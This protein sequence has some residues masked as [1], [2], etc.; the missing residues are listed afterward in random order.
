MREDVVTVQEN[1]EQQAESRTEDGDTGLLL[2]AKSGSVT[3]VSILAP[4]E[5]GHRDAAGLT[6]LAVGI[7]EGKLSICKLLAP[8]EAHVPL[9]INGKEK[10]PLVL[11]L[12]AGCLDIVAI[13][14]EYIDLNNESSTHGQYIIAA[15]SSGKLDVVKY[16]L[17]HCAVDLKSIEQALPIATGEIEAYLKKIH[18]I[19]CI[20]TCPMCGH[21]NVANFSILPL[22]LMAAQSMTEGGSST[23]TATELIEKDKVILSQKLEIERLRKK[24][25][26]LCVSFD[27]ADIGL[28]E[29]NERNDLSYFSESSQ[30]RDLSTI[31]HLDSQ[32]REIRLD[33]LEK[34]NMGREIQ[35]GIIDVSPDERAEPFIPTYQRSSSMPNIFPERLWAMHTD[36]SE[37]HLRDFVSQQLHRYR[38]IRIEQVGNTEIDMHLVKEMQE[39]PFDAQTNPN[40]Y[41][42]HYTESSLTSSAIDLPS[43]ATSSTTSLANYGIAEPAPAPDLVEKYVYLRLRFDTYEDC[44]YG[45]IAEHVLPVT[46]CRLSETSDG[47]LQESLVNAA[48]SHGVHAGQRL[49]SSC[50]EEIS[51]RTPLMVAAAAGDLEGCRSILFD[52]IGKRTN[53]GRT[54]LMFAVEGGYVDVVKLLMDKEAGKISTSRNQIA[55]ITALQI[56]ALRGYDAIVSLLLDTEAGIQDKYGFTA[57]MYASANNNI[58]CIKLLLPKEKGLLTNSKFVTGQGISAL[59]VATA[60]NNLEAVKLLLPAEEYVPRV[61]SKAIAYGAGNEC[62]AYIKAVEEKRLSKL[63]AGT[64]VKSG[65]QP[66]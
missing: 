23:A 54:A 29:Q 5:S 43:A 58:A 47:V 25:A 20:S 56:A 16:A 13:I 27:N 53:S 50:S 31:N 34:E 49:S 60:N 30:L 17:K 24:L 6:A 65:G 22:H 19:L 55:P 7:L 35:I 57:L 4:Y 40:I 8:Y 52:H 42:H 32:D 1:A 10:M 63:R 45:T 51:D 21:V 3:I 66:E 48:S 62:V 38:T 18:D 14:L 61:R 33:N 37:A 26:E 12:E 9:F 44:L 15:V 39:K 11:A 46:L 59:V 64:T 28:E 36:D 2:A 41:A